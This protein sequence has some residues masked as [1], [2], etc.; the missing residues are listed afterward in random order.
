MKF[1]LEVSLHL[2]DEVVELVEIVNLVLC[3]DVMHVEC[4]LLEGLY[5]AKVGDL[6]LSE[7]RF[8]V[9]VIWLRADGKT[10]FSLKFRFCGGND[11]FFG[12]V[13]HEF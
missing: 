13:F 12:L 8:H 6:R 5:G 9:F 2:F 1:L 11:A 3:E 7:G 10:A 4:L